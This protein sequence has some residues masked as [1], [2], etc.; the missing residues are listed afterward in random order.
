[1][2]K[3]VTTKE[4][5]SGK[6]VKL[7]NCEDSCIFINSSI[8]NLKIANCNNCTIFAAAVN[9]ITSIDKCDNS[10]ICIATNYL[11]ISNS[12][13][14]NFY[15]YSNHKPI[16]FGDNRGISFGPHNVHYNTFDQVIKSSKLIIN[17]AN[18][19]LWTNPIDLNQS[20]YFIKEVK[21]FQLMS[22][23]FESNL[24]QLSLCHKDYLNVI[25]ER[26]KQFNLIR[27]WIKEAK[28]DDEQSK[29]LHA[30]IQ[31][32]FRDWLVSSGNIKNITEIVKMI[33]FPDT[34][35]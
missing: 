15:I 32:Y 5:L 27:N 21:D 35:I 16:L 29:G 34:N 20:T 14:S 3:T 19:L 33:D 23:P 25:K 13:E 6:S 2:T 10:N 7:T 1:M 11:R 4:N 31:G 8:N 24:S 26:E 12:I 18:F 22:T 30:A 17:Q 28:L 9:K